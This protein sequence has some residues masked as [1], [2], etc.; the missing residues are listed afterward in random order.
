MELTKKNSRERDVYIL[1]F[2]KCVRDS[3]NS[4]LEINK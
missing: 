2:G 4:Y 3:I 1:D